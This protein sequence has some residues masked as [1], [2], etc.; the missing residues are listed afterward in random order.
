MSDTIISDGVK[1]DNLV[2]I[3]HNVQIGKNTLI[4]AKSM[5]GG[6]TKIGKNCWIGPSSSIINQIEIGNN[7]IV[8]IGTNVLKSCPDFSVVAGNPGKIIRIIKNDDN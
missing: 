1:I 3:A 7:V 4:I 6:S 2:H 8:G 5:I